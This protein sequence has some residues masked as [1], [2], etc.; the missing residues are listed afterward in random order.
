M[1][2]KVFILK[3]GMLNPDIL[4]ETGAPSRFGIKS[5]D[6]LI[7]AYSFVKPKLWTNNKLTILLQF[8]I[9]VIKYLNLLIL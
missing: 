2:G 1:D 6:E 3:N 7:S 5:F 4:Q 9:S 8:F